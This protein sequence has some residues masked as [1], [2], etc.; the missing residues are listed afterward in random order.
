[1]AHTLNDINQFGTSDNQYYV[2]PINDRVMH[3][4]WT[5]Q[6]SDGDWGNFRAWS[7]N[8]PAPAGTWQAK[9]GQQDLDSHFSEGLVA[10]TNDIRFEYNPTKT[11][12]VIVLSGNYVDVKGKTYSGS[13][14]LQPYSSVV[15]I[16]N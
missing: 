7:T 15:L 9:I 13:V 12:K 1:M 5:N 11:N 10:S 14:T 6:A 16:R 4:F 2:R 3:D 8:N